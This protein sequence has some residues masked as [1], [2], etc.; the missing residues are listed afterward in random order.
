MR[1]EIQWFCDQG[2]LEC[3]KDAQSYIN[4]QDCFCSQNKGWYFLA[5][6]TA[7]NSKFARE[8][9]KHMFVYSALLSR[10][11]V[12]VSPASFCLKMRRD[13]LVP[14]TTKI[15]LEIPAFN[16]SNTYMFLIADWRCTGISF[17]S[18]PAVKWWY[19][20]SFNEL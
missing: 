18:V 3:W 1:F 8:K 14:F 7:N 5:Q 20:E 12:L 17:P 15:R 6:T 9:N 11:T 4:A 10:Q 19:F 2:T 13:T 16:Q